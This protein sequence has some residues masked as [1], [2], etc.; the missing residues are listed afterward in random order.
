MQNNQSGSLGDGV[1]VTP[2]SQDRFRYAVQ[3]QLVAPYAVLYASSVSTTPH[4]PVSPYCSIDDVAV[5]PGNAAKPGQFDEGF[6]P[7]ST[8]GADTVLLQ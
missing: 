4:L 7:T 6:I 8:Q 5:N 2:G 1:L 3:G